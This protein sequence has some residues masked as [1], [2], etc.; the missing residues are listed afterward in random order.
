MFKGGGISERSAG[1][2]PALRSEIPP[3]HF[4]ESHGVVLIRIAFA[5]SFGLLL[6]GCGGVQSA[7]DP[8]GREA[9]RIA[10][11]FWWMTAGAVIVWLAM[12]GLALYF[13]RQRPEPLSPRQARRF[14]LWGGGRSRR[15]SC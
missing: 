8:A 4:L 3:K 11:I 9:A 12:I 7:L 5:A 6:G 14:I 13:A 10:G 1:W 2:E 15:P